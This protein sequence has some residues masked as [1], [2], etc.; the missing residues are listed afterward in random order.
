MIVLWLALENCTDI[1]YNKIFLIS[2]LN[3]YVAESNTLSTEA[4]ILN[5]PRH[6]KT[7]FLNMQKQRPA[8]S[9]SLRW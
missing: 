4:Q 7:C 6:E 5:E 1:H 3:E 8:S 2:E 9:F